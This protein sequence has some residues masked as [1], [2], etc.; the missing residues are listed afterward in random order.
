[1][2]H[3]TQSSSKKRK[4]VA[5]RRL[6]QNMELEVSVDLL[7]EA[8]CLW[9]TAG[10]AICSRAS[11]IIPD[12]FRGPEAGSVRQSGLR[13][14]ELSGP[15]I[16]DYVL[17]HAFLRRSVRWKSRRIQRQQR[18]STIRGMFYF[19]TIGLPNLKSCTAASLTIYLYHAAWRQNM[20]HPLPRKLGQEGVGYG[21][22]WNRVEDRNA[23]WRRFPGTCTSKGA[24]LDDDVRI[25]LIGPPFEF[26]SIKC[27]KGREENTMSLIISDPGLHFFL[28]SSKLELFPVE[29]VELILKREF[30]KYFQRFFTIKK[31]YSMWTRVWK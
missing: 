19:S 21:P 1:M 13:I 24:R 30:L 20:F 11:V 10:Q 25:F 16:L 22:F 12:I 26:G 27:Q 6:Y 28:P 4:A 29:Y 5:S 9:A 17:P 7:G 15:R 23:Q 8:W 3:S 18:L 31:L 14:F 2:S